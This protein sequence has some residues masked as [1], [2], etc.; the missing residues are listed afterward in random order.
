MKILR[1]RKGRGDCG[2]ELRM[3]EL[4]GFVKAVVTL[5]SHYKCSYSGQSDNISD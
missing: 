2:N 5:L 3:S 1:P 4:E